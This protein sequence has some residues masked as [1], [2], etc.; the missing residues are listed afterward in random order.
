[1]KHHKQ[2]IINWFVRQLIDGTKVRIFGDGK[3][4]RDTNYVDDVVEAMLIAMHSDKT[5]GEVYNLGG[6]PVNLV[7]IVKKMIAINGS[8][9]F[10]TVAFPKESKQIE[11]GDYIAD[12]SKFKNATGWTPKIGL[13]EGMEKTFEYYRKNMKYYW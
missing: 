1:M 7:D 2:G 10:E 5:N 8:G 4:I 3:Q 13:D 9:E 12:Y 6:V 11:I